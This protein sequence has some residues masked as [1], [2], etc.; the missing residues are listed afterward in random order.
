V[1]VAVLTEMS[2][3]SAS[4]RYRALQHLPR[5]R[6]EFDSVDVFLARDEVGRAPG[7]VGRSRYFGTHAVRYVRRWT[8]LRR[9]VARYDSVLVQRGLYPLGPGGV[10]APVERF[11]GRVVLDL[12]DAVFVA[13][14]EL[15]R[16]SRVARWLYGPQQAI[17]LIRRA[18][19]IVVSTT[20]LAEALPSG[21]RTPVVLP[22]VPDPACYRVADHS[23]TRPVAVW[24]G[25]TGG[26][27]FLDSLVSV[28]RQLRDAHIGTLEVVSSR[29]WEGP[30]TFRAWRLDQ[31]H[32]LF[33]D[34]AV[35]IMPLPDTQY[36]RSKAGF[37][38]LQYMSAGLPVVASPVG[39]N[40]W[41][42][43]ESGGGYLA[44]DATEWKAALTRLLAD[45]EHRAEL[46]RR[47]REFVLRYSDLDHQADVLAGLLHR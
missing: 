34:Y 7:P 41:L 17:R 1:E 15:A 20:A 27:L 21:S 36:T 11:D 46:G 3:W 28:L 9:V 6:Q 10:T 16:K 12:D 14:P 8:E 23:R 26:L 38:L 30:A 18:D 47:G 29:P 24:A 45:P 35:G 5:L 13:A 44:S 25:T 37:K 32:L 22:S 40:A 4:T 31:E 33:A 39:I 2:A 19:G 42:V 43:E